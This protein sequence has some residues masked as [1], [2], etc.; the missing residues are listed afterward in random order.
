MGLTFVDGG[1]GNI[2]DGGLLDHVA[3]QEALDGLV[4]GDA[5]RAVGASQ[6]LDMSSSVLGTT[7]VPSLDRLPVG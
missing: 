1:L 3:N 4:L 5:A 7:M 6:E 2:A